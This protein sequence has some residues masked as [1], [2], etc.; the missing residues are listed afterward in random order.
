MIAVDF[1]SVYNQKRICNDGRVFD[2]EKSEELIT[3][4]SDAESTARECDTMHSY[5]SEDI[6]ESEKELEYQQLE[7]NHLV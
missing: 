5:L 2:L 6:Y 4:L 1:A 3:N 7:M